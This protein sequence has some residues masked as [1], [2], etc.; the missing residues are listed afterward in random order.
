MCIKV[1]LTASSSSIT[2]FFLSLFNALAQSCPPA[3]KDDSDV[4]VVIETAKISHT[5]LD[6]IRY[7]KALNFHHAKASNSVSMSSLLT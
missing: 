7:F 2:N 3:L 6:K 4:T 1:S 5:I